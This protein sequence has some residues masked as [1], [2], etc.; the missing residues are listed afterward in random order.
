MVDKESLNDATTQSRDTHLLAIDN[1]EDQ[2]L[3]NIQKWVQ[4]YCDAIT[5]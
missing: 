4:N 2:L 5:M 3:T 1:R